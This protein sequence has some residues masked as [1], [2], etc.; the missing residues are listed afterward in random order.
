M[1]ER[2]TANVR[3]DVPP[4]GRRL[5]EL[6]PQGHPVGRRAGLPDPLA[7]RLGDRHPARPGLRLQG[8]QVIALKRHLHDPPALALQPRS[9]GCL[10]VLA[11]YPQHGSVTP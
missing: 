10:S 2:P 6:G 11:G 8:G 7:Q 4:P 1:G 5:I 3:E 9:E